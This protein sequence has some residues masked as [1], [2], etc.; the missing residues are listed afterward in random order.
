MQHSFDEVIDELFSIR[1]KDRRGDLSSHIEGLPNPRDYAMEIKELDDASQRLIMH[2][3]AE[4][5]NVLRPA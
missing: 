4:A 3:N 5:L 1:R 2:D